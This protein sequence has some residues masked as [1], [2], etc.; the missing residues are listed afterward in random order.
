MNEQTDNTFD[1]KTLAEPSTCTE[2]DALAAS[3][4]PS[5][6]G[7]RPPHAQRRAPSEDFRRKRSFQR[8]S[9]CQT[10]DRC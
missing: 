1:E 4:A 8:V 5:P 10:G 2:L 3:D 7:A 6:L 9:E